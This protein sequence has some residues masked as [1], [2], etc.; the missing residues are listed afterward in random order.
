MV[1]ARGLGN[2]RQDDACGLEV[3][4]FPQPLFYYRTEAGG[5]LQALTRGPATAFR[6]RAHMINR[7][8]VDA[9]LTP[10]E[11]CDLWECLL[12]FDRF[13]HEGLKERM[14]EQRL[15]HDSQIE[16]LNGWRLAQLDELRAQLGGQVEAQ[17]VRAEVAEG[18]LAALRAVTPRRLLR[19]AAPVPVV[20]SPGLQGE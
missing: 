20:A 1:A 15:W 4:V 10:R 16:D 11:R 18:E 13:I 3:E 5:R 9:E 12:G 6:Q 2:L 8:F 7:F 14:T 19:R 17:R